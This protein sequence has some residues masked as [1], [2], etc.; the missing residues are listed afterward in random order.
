MIRP[1]RRSV[2]I[3][4][5]SMADI[6][7]LLLVFFLVTTC[8][9]EDR[10]LGII[11][12]GEGSGPVLKKH[13]MH[14]IVRDQDNVQILYRDTDSMIPRTDLR[15]IAAQ[16][17]KEDPRLIVSL[18]TDPS[19]PYEAMIRALDELRAADVRRISIGQLTS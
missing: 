6:A 1:T 19:A 14:V 12:P 8:F 17:L 4:T 16:R 13:L 11:L 15:T 2:E 3:P 10:G 9:L 5:A 7:F 18:K